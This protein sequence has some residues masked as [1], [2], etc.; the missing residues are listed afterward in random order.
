[1]LSRLSA[2]SFPM[3]MLSAAVALGQAA[4]M[5]APAAT[6]TAPGTAS[7]LVQPSV[8]TLNQA[9]GM[10]R[11]EKWKVSR[12]VREATA[13]NIGSIRHD[14]DATLP[15]LI[16]TADASP[17]S[18][19]AMLPL[20]RNLGALY[21]VVLRV[22]VIAESGAPQEQLGALEQ[23]MTSLEGARRGLGDR[24]QNVVEAQEQQIS[25]LQKALAARPA[26]VATPAPTAVPVTPAVHPKRKK[27]PAAKPATTPASKPS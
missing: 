12:N 22:A 16:S 18:I 8:G 15:G 26:P 1:M 9:L 24:L 7:G 25:D 23:A 27:K 20:T 19:S 10:L 4:T 14:L 2:V 3:M 17:G 11:V 13:T 21:D 6:A 5:P